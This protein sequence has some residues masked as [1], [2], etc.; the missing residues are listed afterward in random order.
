[1]DAATGRPQAMFPVGSDGLS[2]SLSEHGGTLYAAVSD[3]SSYGSTLYAVDGR[4]GKQRWKLRTDRAVRSTTVPSDEAVYFSSGNGGPAVLH[5]VDPASAQ[6]LWTA[7]LG[8]GFW[9]SAPVVSKEA[10]FVCAGEESGKST[11]TAFNR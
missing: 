11:L 8:H 2:Q 3:G 7:T 1:M 5:A 4:S 6:T 10:V 9:Y